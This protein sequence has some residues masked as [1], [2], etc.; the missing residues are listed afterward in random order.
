MSLCVLDTVVSSIL[1][2]PSAT[3]SLCSDINSSFIGNP[4]SYEDD[5]AAACLAASYSIRPI[6]NEIVDELYEKKACSTAVAERLLDD[7]NQWS[8][9]LPDSLRTSPI[10]SADAAG[11][12]RRI[13]GNVHV[14]CLYYFT[15]TLITRPFLVLTIIDEPPIESQSDFNIPSHDD[16]TSRRLASACLDAALYLVQTC[17]DV[18]KSDILLFNMCILK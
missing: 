9:R 3:S 11:M 6:I 17:W 2:R 8:E 16:P 1:G 14:S 4:L 12:Q 13:I 5:H 10:P 7:L 18:Y 15:L